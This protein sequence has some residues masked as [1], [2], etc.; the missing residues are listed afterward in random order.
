MGASNWTYFVPYQPDLNQ[1]LQE[2]REAVFR[3]GDYYG[4]AEWYA[5]L[6]A[7]RISDD[8]CGYVITQV[9]SP[10]VRS[11]PQTI[12]D[13]LERNGEQGTHSI[14]DIQ[15]IAHVPFFGVAAP[16]T[17]QQLKDLFGTDRPTRP[18]IE[19]AQAELQNLRR[20][21]EGVYVVVYKD[22][23]PD[24]IVFTGRSGD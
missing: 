5:P 7:K 13:L 22:G 17:P 4:P 20:P 8:R 9:A 15:G 2:L 14:L 24:E 21:W 3:Q 11:G 23:R 16:L 10:E 6:W 1:A 12:L 18:M 19:Q